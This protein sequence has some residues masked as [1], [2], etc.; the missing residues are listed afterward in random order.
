LV[1]PGFCSESLRF[2][3][4]STAEV[5]APVLPRFF[6]VTSQSGVKSM[7]LSLD[8]ARERV[9]G[10]N[11]A[12]VQCAS[13]MWTFRY[14]DGYTVTLHGPF[15]AHIIVI[16][17]GPLTMLK[18]DH[19]QFDSNFYEKLISMDQICGS[20]LDANKTPQVLNAP[21]PSPTV[22][23]A[24]VLP[25]PPSQLP[26]SPPSQAGQRGDERWEGPWITYERAFI[27]AEPV[28]AF[29]IP[30]ITMRHLEVRPPNRL[31]SEESSWPFR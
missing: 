24:G 9:V 26:Q 19:I 13:A 16:P 7:R 12:M 8:G 6:L 21:T 29:G 14:H 27:R 4:T 25:Q 17:N 1:C 20:R 30:Q 18:I 23:G 3:L 31:K 22:N 10:P 28:N 11:H 2:L 15:T 5:S